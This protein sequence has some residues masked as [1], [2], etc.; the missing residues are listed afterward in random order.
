MEGEPYHGE[1]KKRNLV[2]SEASKGEKDASL[3]WEGKPS[4]CEEKKKGHCL[5]ACRERMRLLVF[6]RRESLF[7][8]SL[9]AG[10]GGE[11]RHI[12]T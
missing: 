8:R 6:M 5:S 10:E 11:A 4:S 2:S 12:G 7:R 9:H 3:F 1:K